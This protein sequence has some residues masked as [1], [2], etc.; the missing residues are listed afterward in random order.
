MQE[1]RK[2]LWIRRI[3]AMALA[4]VMTV[5]SVPATALAAPGEEQSAMEQNADEDSTKVSDSEDDSTKEQ[6]GEP[7]GDEM[8]VTEDADGMNASEETNTGSEDAD[9][10]DTSEETNADLEGD[11]QSA[12]L[13]NADQEAA[14]PENEAEN[15]VMGDTDAAA[16]GDQQPEAV[17]VFVAG[18]EIWLPISRPNID[19]VSRCLQQNQQM[20]TAGRPWRLIRIFCGPFLLRVKMAVKCPCRCSALSVS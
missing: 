9:S 3:L 16:E 4:V 18:V 2:R 11:K 1:F 5:T 10:M 15:E 13:E 14:A 12:D 8:Q 20:R 17:Y 19:G 7:S 6:T